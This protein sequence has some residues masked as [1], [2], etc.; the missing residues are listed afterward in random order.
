MKQTKN[1]IHIFNNVLCILVGFLLCPHQLAADGASDLWKLAL[2]DS[3]VLNLF[4]DEHLLIHNV[5][6]KFLQDLKTK[7]LVEATFS[8]TSNLL[9]LL[10]LSLSLSCRDKKRAN[11]VSEQLNIVLQNA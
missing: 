6:E 4:R 1:G 2:Q 9:L 3:Y 7:E 5:F 10:F 11:E 8:F